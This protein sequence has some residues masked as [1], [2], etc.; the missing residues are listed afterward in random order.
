MATVRSLMG[1]QHGFA[2]LLSPAIKRYYSFGFAVKTEEEELLDELKAI[3]RSIKREHFLLVVWRCFLTCMRDL[4]W[5]VES[6]LG[7]AR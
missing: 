4:V 5:A 2:E 7:G 3:E 1:N 6:V